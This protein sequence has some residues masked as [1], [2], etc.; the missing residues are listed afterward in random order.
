MN[1]IIGF[2]RRHQLVV[3]FILVF[4]LSWFMLVFEPHVLMPLGPLMAALIVLAL[5]SGRA[6]VADFLRRIVRWRVGWRWYA[7]A[8]GLPLAAA[9]VATGLNVLLGA[10]YAFDRFP[11]A[12]DLL[13]ASVFIVLAIGLGEEPAWRGFVLPRLMIGRSV[14]GAS[15]LLGLIH[16]VWH[17]PLFGLEYNLQNGLPWALS[18]IAISVVTAWMYI[19]TN[20]NLLLPVLLHSTV[21]I[22]ARTT[23]AL[24]SG[25]DVIQ[26]YWLWGGFIVVAAVVVIMVAGPDFRRKGAVSPVGIVDAASRSS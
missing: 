18:V 11:T 13:G 6:G 1:A 17:Y 8:I 21:N 19:R 24:F 25:S 3:F 9:A 23:F 22:S 7:L 2:A 4:P 26:L 20:G 14:L 10:S 15:L 5:V 16:I 12:M